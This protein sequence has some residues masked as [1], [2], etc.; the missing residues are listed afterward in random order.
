MPHKSKQSN[1]DRVCGKHLTLPITGLKEYGSQKLISLVEHEIQFKAAPQLA[2]DLAM[3]QTKRAS[4]LS[5]SASQLSKS[6]KPG[7]LS[8]CEPDRAV[9]YAQLK[10]LAQDLTA[11][12]NDAAN[13]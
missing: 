12:D 13:V 6:K 11:G 4:S 5:I 9:R 10:G 8:M 3:T 1:I 2:E 7:R